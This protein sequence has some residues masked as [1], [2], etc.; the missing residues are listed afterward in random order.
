MH[1]D[2]T[3]AYRPRK[4][5]IHR[6]DP[7]VK[8]VVAL[9]Y[10]L[11][12]VAM[13]DGEW[14]AFGLLQIV[15]LAFAWRSNLGPFYAFRRAFIALPFILAALPIPFLMPGPTVWTMPVVGWGVSA[16]GLVRFLS[17]LLRTWLAVQA[18]ILLSATTRLPEIL[19]ALSVLRVPATLVSI[20]GFM[21]RYIFILADEAV[22]MLRA[23]SA[24]SPKA[25]GPSRPSLLWQGRMAGMMVGSLFLRS[26]ERS[27]RVYEAMLSRGYAGQVRML[28][29]FHMGR[30]DWLALLMA[31]VLLAVPVGLML[32]R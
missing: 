16:P 13:P 17:I 21:Y 24:R 8:L 14:E 15:A 9:L 12:T 6:L 29:A 27:E 7:R 26:L 20:I 30:G 5:A 25:T 2:L 11:T 32:I 1:F 4:S 31:G 10:I 23:R 22:R 18:G 19:W 3:D 28:Q